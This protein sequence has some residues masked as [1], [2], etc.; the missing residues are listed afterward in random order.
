M[1]LQKTLEVEQV[2]KLVRKMDYLTEIYSFSE[3]SGG[4]HDPRLV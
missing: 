3:E 1:I 2:P 4:K